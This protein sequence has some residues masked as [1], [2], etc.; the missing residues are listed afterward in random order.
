MA[1]KQRFLGPQ[2]FA[3]ILKK[4][5]VFFRRHTGVAHDLADYVFKDFPTDDVGKGEEPT[6]VF[7]FSFQSRFCAFLLQYKAVFPDAG[8]RLFMYDQVY[9]CV[10]A[11]IMGKT[12][13]RSTPV[14]VIGKDCEP[15]CFA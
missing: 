14:V 13:A 15:R 3:S 10:F 12:I 4:N 2:E 5:F 1:L 9:R 7:P 6:A 11:K 8:S